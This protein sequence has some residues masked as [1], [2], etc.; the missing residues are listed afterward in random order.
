[1]YDGILLIPALA[2]FAS[3]KTW[4]GRAALFG[5]S[6]LP[7]LAILASGSRPIALLGSSLIVISTCVVVAYSNSTGVTGPREFP[8]DS[9]PELDPVAS[10][11]RLQQLRERHSSW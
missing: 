7:F 5:L 11:P 8:A 6:P 3:L 1:M 4:S 2:R 9:T 10:T